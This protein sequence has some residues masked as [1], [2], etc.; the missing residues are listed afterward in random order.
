MFD[1]R[2]LFDEI[3]YTDEIKTGFL[4]FL[5]C[6]NRPIHELLNPKYIDQRTVFYSQFS[7]LTDRSFSYDEFEETRKQLVS[8]VNESLTIY[9]KEF[10]LAFAKCEPVWNDI[11]YSMF[12]AIRWKMFNIQKLKNSNPKKFQEQIALLQQILFG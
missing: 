3:G 10:I 6:S 4:F 5:L 7:G 1:V 9:D 8:K 11:D 2:N 12:P